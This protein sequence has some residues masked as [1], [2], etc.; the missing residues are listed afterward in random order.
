MDLLLQTAASLVAIL[1]LAGLAWWM[2]LGGTP[3]LDSEAAVCRA[4]G[5]VEDGFVP[6]AMAYD[7][8]AALARDGGGR[9]MVIKRHGSRLAGRVLDA[10][11]RAAIRRDPGRPA[12]EV[13]CGEARF[14][15]VVIDL[16][17][18]QAWAEAINGLDPSRHA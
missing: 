11:A 12:L 5:E 17:E 7:G 14:G 6:L 16:P 13:D 10:C 1:A 2:K 15:K 8:K 3:A 18:P 9:I 4:A